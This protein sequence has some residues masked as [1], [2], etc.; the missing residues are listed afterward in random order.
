VIS[1]AIPRRSGGSMKTI[2]N[3]LVADNVHILFAV[4]Q[5]F[6]QPWDRLSF[7]R[8]SPFS[9]PTHTSR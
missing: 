6:A 5:R 4:G 2:A 8:R 1:A 3:L 7:G 9:S